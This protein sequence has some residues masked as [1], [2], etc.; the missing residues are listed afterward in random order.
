MGTHQSLLSL[1][2]L[3]GISGVRS[4]IPENVA[5]FFPVA[6]RPFSGWGHSHNWQ[7]SQE[8][9]FGS[10]TTFWISHQLLIALIFSK[11]EAN[12]GPYHGSLSRCRTLASVTDWDPSV[13]HRPLV[14]FAKNSPML[15]EHLLAPSCSVEFF[16]SRPATAESGSRQP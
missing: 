8:S 3:R 5:Q 9:L 15:R 10:R 16:L 11:E 2:A 6:A 13:E 12:L 1:F 14:F 4:S 7:S